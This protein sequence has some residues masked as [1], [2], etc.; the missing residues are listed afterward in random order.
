MFHV[1]LT[2]RNFNSLVDDEFKSSE[3]LDVNIF[4]RTVPLKTL[5]VSLLQFNNKTENNNSANPLS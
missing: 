5:I 3:N 1:S 4:V 2:G